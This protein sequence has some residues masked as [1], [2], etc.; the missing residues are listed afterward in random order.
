MEAKRNNKWG[1]ENESGYGAFRNDDL[2]WILWRMI[3]R[4]KYR[5]SVFFITGHDLESWTIKNKDRGIGQTYNDLFLSTLQYQMDISEETIMEHEI[6]MLHKQA[7]WG[8]RFKTGL[9]WIQCSGLMQKFDSDKHPMKDKLKVFSK[10]KYIKRAPKMKLIDWWRLERVTLVFYLLAI[11]A[12]SLEVCRKPLEKK[13]DEAIKKK[14][15]FMSKKKRVKCTGCWVGSTITAV[16]IMATFLVLSPS[17]SKH[18][19]ER[20]HDMESLVIGYGIDS[21]EIRGYKVTKGKT[22]KSCNRTIQWNAEFS[23]LYY[24][25]TYKDVQKSIEGQSGVYFRSPTDLLILCFHNKLRR[26][27]YRNYRK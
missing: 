2:N 17:K 22:I 23:Q 19:R 9:L 16:I 8:D 13:R 14:G 1:V 18:K 26:G 24:S 11:I 25:H 6:M 20:L 27:W 15:K 5:N 21:L 10:V 4:G 7:F 12:V 3:L